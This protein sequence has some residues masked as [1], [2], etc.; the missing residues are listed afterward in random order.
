[1]GKT[2]WGAMRPLT[3][4]RTTVLERCALNLN[5]HP[6]LDSGSSG[7]KLHNERMR[8]LDAESSS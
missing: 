2:E 6:E 1:V 5:R 7:V 8:L 4:E 3:I